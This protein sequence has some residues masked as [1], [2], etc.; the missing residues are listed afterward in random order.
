MLL[1]FAECGDIAI[2][3]AKTNYQV[4]FSNLVLALVVSLVIGVLSLIAIRVQ[5][6]AAA[7]SRKGRSAGV[8]DHQNEAQ[9]LLITGQREDS[10]HGMGPT[11]E[12]RN[13]CVVAGQRSLLQ[14]ITGQI[15][16]GKVTAIMG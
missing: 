4:D 1:V 2:C 15:P 11:V 16:G 5:Q 8:P 10:H 3:S 7:A 6:R 12:F 13:L 9:P 14:E